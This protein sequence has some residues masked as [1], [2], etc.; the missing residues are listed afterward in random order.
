MIFMIGYMSRVGSDVAI[1]IYID[2]YDDFKKQMLYTWGSLLWD[3]IPILCLLFFHYANFKPHQHEL[4]I[5]I[6]NQS[7][8]AISD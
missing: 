2:K 3:G 7:D 5:R 4:I 6:N 8:K 1:I